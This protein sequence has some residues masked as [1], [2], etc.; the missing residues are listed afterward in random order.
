MGLWVIMRCEM[1]GAGNGELRF[2][3]MEGME[4]MDAYRVGR[5]Y[6]ERPEQEWERLDLH[7]TEFAVTMRALS[8]YMPP[9]PS[10]VLDVGGGPGRYAVELARQRYEVT[11]LDMSRRMLDY[12]ELKAEE[13][14]VRL[15]GCV[16]ANAMDLSLFPDGSYDAVLLMGPLYHLLRPKDRR[17]CVQEAGR[18]LKPGGVVFASFITRYTPIR[19]WAKHDPMW[20]IQNPRR[21][22]EILVTGLNIAPAGFT[23]SYFA[24]PSEVAPLMEH[25]GF[26]KLDLIACEGVISMIEEKVNQLTDEPWQIWVE[27][28]YQLGK[29]PLVHGCAEHLL[30]VGR[31]WT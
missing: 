13:A 30:Y 31:R 5:Y 6:D 27:M 19:Y 11:L 2:G 15:A 12:A 3:G 23:D 16:Q 21:N 14:G 4:G 1:A 18:V 29:D 17:R 10:R 8:D 25:G 9:P 20:V 26:E 28:N 22:E 7:R 24:H